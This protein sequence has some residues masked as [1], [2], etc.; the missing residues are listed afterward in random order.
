MNSLSKWPEGETRGWEPDDEPS[1]AVQKWEGYS[2]EANKQV[3]PHTEHPQLRGTALGRW[4]LKDLVLETD[5]SCTPGELKGVFKELACCITCP[6]T[7]HQSRGLKN[8]HIREIYWLIL[9][10]VLEG[11]GCA[12][13]YVSLPSSLACWTLTGTHCDTLHLFVLLTGLPCPSQHT[14]PVRCPSKAA[15]TLPGG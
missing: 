4:P 14:C 11:E 6:G 13:G 2:W 8:H 10:H 9:G 5:R 15:P 12:R 7:Q 3:T 1:V